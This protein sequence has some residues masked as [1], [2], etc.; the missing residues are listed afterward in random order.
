MQKFKIHIKAETEAELR[1]ELEE[2]AFL[3][4]GLSESVN[5]FDKV[6]GSTAAGIKNRWKGKADEWK[7]RHKV[8]YF[9]HSPE[10]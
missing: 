1:K 9:D 10:K 7:D 6:F 8:I 4:V 3:L 2:A 5:H